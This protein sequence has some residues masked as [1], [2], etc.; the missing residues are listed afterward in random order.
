MRPAIHVDR[1][2]GVGAPDVEDVDPLQVVQ[3]DELDAVRR[4]HLSRRT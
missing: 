1:P 4:L 3:L 2:P